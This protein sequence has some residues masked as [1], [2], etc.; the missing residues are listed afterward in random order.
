MGTHGDD[1]IAGIQWRL[2]TRKIVEE[3][4]RE[5]GVVHS[6][7]PLVPAAAMPPHVGLWHCKPDLWIIAGDVPTDH[8]TLPR[9]ARDGR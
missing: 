4:L 1:G 2:E 9:W 6:A 3:Y 8:L 5:Q 7:V